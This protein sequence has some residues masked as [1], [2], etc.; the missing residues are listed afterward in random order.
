MIY[1]LVSKQ[2]SNRE[3]ATIIRVHSSYTLIGHCPLKQFIRLSFPLVNAII[4]TR[5]NSD[6]FHFSL[7]T[8]I[9]LPNARNSLG[10]CIRG[11]ILHNTTGS[12]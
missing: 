3:L 6:I 1:S 2:V 12:R 8:S 11:H 5:A 7:V 4:Q 9:N 10:P